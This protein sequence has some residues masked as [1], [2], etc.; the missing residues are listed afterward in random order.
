[1]KTVFAIV[2]AVSMVGITVPAVAQTVPTARVSFADL[3]TANSAGMHVLEMRVSAAA[4]IV[5]GS[6]ATDLTDKARIAKCRK[7]A[8]ADAMTSFARKNAPVYA[9]R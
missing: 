3:D 2:V 9:S 1:M 4:R 6:D 7:A 8:I 5:C